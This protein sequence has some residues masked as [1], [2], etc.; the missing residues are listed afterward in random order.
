MDALEHV[1]CSSSHTV[2]PHAVREG[3]AMDLCCVDHWN[4]L[5]NGGRVDECCAAFQSLTGRL[6]LFLC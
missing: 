3:K 4:P 1:R 2:R 5:S 6:D